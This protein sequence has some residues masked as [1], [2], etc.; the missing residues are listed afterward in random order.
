MMDTQRPALRLQV[1]GAVNPRSGI[2]IVR[3]SDEEL[4]QLLERGE[5]ANVFCSRQT[6]KTSL[7]KRTKLRLSGSG[8]LTAEVEIPGYLGSPNNADEWYQG[9]LDRV[10]SQLHL[11]I[12]IADWWKNCRAITANQRLIQFFRD[13]IAART[14]QPVVIFL[15][16]IDHTISLPYTDDF[17]VA[18]RA[19]YNDRA[20]EPLFERITFCLIGVVTPSELIQNLRTTPYN[21]GQTI[22][23]P[24]FDPD[25][26]DLT[27][28]FK[29][30]SDD[31]TVGEAI[32][33]AVLRWTGGH[34]YLTIRLCEQFSVHGV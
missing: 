8:Y 22:E 4:P 20:S 29:A 18:I 23:L 33:R 12:D 2:Y 34:P 3:P 15:D 5:Y 1:G 7:L 26:D 32:V 27:L 24:D 13:E 30:V 19:M 11:N 21:V 31:A 17:F 14:S 9:L 16:E 28:L 25:R 10:A 6:G